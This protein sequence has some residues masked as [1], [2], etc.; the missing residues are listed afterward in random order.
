MSGPYRSASPPGEDERDATK[1][2]GVV[3]GAHRSRH[4]RPLTGTAIATAMGGLLRV[5]I[6]EHGFRFQ[7]VDTEDKPLPFAEI[8]A[9]HYEPGLIAGPPRLVLVTFDAVRIELPPDLD[10]LDVVIDALDREVTRPVL[11]RAKQALAAGEPLTF[12]PLVLELD[13]IVLRGK[14]LPW[15]ALTRVVAERDA[16]VFYAALD[17]DTDHRFGWTKLADLPHPAVLLALLQL[18]TAL[19]M[20]GLHLRTNP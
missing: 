9:I 4:S 6:H 15:S 14:S 3:L 19:T 7:G 11:T 2:S 12:G 10:D 1:T 16:L 18:R 20:A 8:D 5:D 17:A 13:G